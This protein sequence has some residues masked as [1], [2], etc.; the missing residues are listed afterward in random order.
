MVLKDNSKYSV[1]TD[2]LDDFLLLQNI[3]NRNISE[4]AD[5]Y[6]NSIFIYPYS[7]KCGRKI[8]KVCLDWQIF[9]QTN[10]S[11]QVFERTKYTLI[12]IVQSA[13]TTDLCACNPLITNQQ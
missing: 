12:G 9:R 7:F 11:K 5:E 13:E 8:K 6:D 4:L 3:A 2:N 10:P 1:S